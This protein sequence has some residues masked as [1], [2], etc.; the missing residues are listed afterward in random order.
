MKT[1]KFY[2]EDGIW[3]IDLPEFLELG[4][5]TKANLMMVGG[6]D[7]YLDRLSNYTTEVTVSFSNVDFNGST[8]TLKRTKLGY[9]DIYLDSVGHAQV[10]GGA[11]YQSTVDGHELWLCPVTK[12]VFQANYPEYIF[13]KKEQ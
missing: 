6:S 2:K 4:L 1:H 3:Y 7:T 8:D 11:Y 10:D 12:Y 13:I 5:G 9:D